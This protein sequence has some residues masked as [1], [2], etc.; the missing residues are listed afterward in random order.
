MGSDWIGVFFFPVST[1]DLETQAYGEPGDGP[2]E[3][4]V[5]SLKG[6][7]ILFYYSYYL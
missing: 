5:R 6:I 2:A 7:H 3:T 1:D 4:E